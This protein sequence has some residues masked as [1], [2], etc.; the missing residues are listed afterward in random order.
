MDSLSQIEFYFFSARHD[1]SMIRVFAETYKLNQYPNIKIVGM[2]TEFFFFSFYKVKFVPDLAL[3][4]SKKKLIKL[5]E[6]EFTV[7]TIWD[8]THTDS[9]IK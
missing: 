4:D 8:L 2:D 3:Y 5:L 6:G 9:V 1:L 7:K